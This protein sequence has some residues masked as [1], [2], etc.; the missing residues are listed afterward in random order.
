M[1]RSLHPFLV[2]TLAAAA[3]AAAVQGLPAQTPVRLVGITDTTPLLV[4]QDPATCNATR[5]PPGFAPALAH[6]AAGGTAHDSRSGSVW[7]SNGALLARFELDCKAS[8]PAVPAPSLIGPNAF[9]TGLACNERQGI[10]FMT[11]HPPAITT[12]K[13]TCPVP[14]GTTCRPTYVPTGH[15]IGGAATSDLLDLLFVSTSD[16]SAAAG[17]SNMVYVSRQGDPCNAFCRF[18]VKT[19]GTAAAIGPITGLAFDDCK[20][21]LYATDGMRTAAMH[22]DLASCAVRPLQCCPNPAGERLIGLCLVPSKATSLGKSCNARPCPACPAMAHVTNGDPAL[23]NV[24]FALQ[25]QDAPAN[26]Q[27]IMLLNVGPCTAPGV[28]SPPLCAPL[29]VPPA[30]WAVVGPLGTG[31]VGGCTGSASIGLPIPLNASL[32]GWTLSSQYL[33]VCSSPVGVGFGTSNC[34]SWTISGS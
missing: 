9:V 32:C 6:P 11:Q 22:F 34:L 24:A 3:A 29:L 25:L 1:T 27:A 7:V 16:F 26:A 31:G 17:P 21:V 19:C 28:L 20:R 5:C 18:E 8:C 12:L 10:L 4:V 13:A 33:V 14:Q 23:G 2:V 30:G 15:V